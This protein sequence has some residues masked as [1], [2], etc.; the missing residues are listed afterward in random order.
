MAYREWL[1]VMVI[2]RQDQL[3]VPELLR[4]GIS[5]VVAETVMA[6]REGEISLAR[7]ALEAIAW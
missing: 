2:D 7:A 6:D 4:L 1:D 3:L 5:P